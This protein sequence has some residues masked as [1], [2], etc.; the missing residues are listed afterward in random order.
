MYDNSNLSESYQNAT[1]SDEQKNQLNSNLLGFTEILAVSWDLFK[2]RLGD[3]FLPI[4]I[5]QLIIFIVFMVVEGVLVYSATNLIPKGSSINIPIPINPE[6]GDLTREFIDSIYTILSYPGMMV[7]LIGVISVG[8]M[9]ALISQWLDYK[10]KIMINDDSVKVL[11]G[12]IFGNK[13]FKLIVINTVIFIIYNL[14]TELLE[15]KGIIG[16]D[17]LLGL[18]S[19]LFT[20]GFIYFDIVYDYVTR[21]FLYENITFSDSYRLMLSR[22]KNYL[23]GDILRQVIA[24]LIGLVTIFVGGFLY[25]LSMVLI[26]IPL[27]STAFNNNLGSGILLVLAAILTIIAVVFLAVITWVL[28]CYQ[29][30]CYYNLRMLGGKSS[31]NEFYETDDTSIKSQTLEE[32]LMNRSFNPKTFEQSQG[33]STEV[34][35]TYESTSDNSNEIEPEFVPAYQPSTQN[36]YGSS[37]Y[38]TIEEFQMMDI[39]EPLEHRF[40]GQDTTIQSKTTIIGEPKKIINTTSASILGLASIKKTEPKSEVGVG[41]PDSKSYAS[42]KD[43]LKIIEGIG[44]KIEEL[45][46]DNGIF[47]YIQLAS[48]SVLEIQEIL[49]IGGSRFSIHNPITWAKQA[50]LA[51]DGKM[52]ELDILKAELN[53]GV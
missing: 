15:S 23:G 24:F 46:N 34:Y 22:V 1:F 32:S 39:E 12:R 25:I 45:L 41:D 49:D 51:R 38:E 28:E 21:A 42:Q 27:V 16:L 3:L 17:I 50:T 43:D 8:A 2:K 52:D 14:I 10:A 7:V 11:D 6:T 37:S 29:Y 44:P 35:D 33:S 40:D 19:F 9:F 47:T 20:I 31:T 18:V 48:K 4:L 30:V 5:W 53:G 13:F 36:G 26:S